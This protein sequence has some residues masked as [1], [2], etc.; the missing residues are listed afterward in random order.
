MPSE[1]SVRF[2]HHK[3]NSIEVFIERKDQGTVNSQIVKKPPLYCSTKQRPSLAWAREISLR[4]AR[5]AIKCLTGQSPK[6][7]QQFTSP[8]DGADIA[9]PQVRINWGGW[10]EPA[11]IGGL[12]DRQVEWA[13]KLAASTGAARVSRRHFSSRG[14]EL[15]SIFDAA[16]VASLHVVG[17]GRVFEARLKGI[18]Q[19][20]SQRSARTQKAGSFTFRSRTWYRV[21]N[22]LDTHFPRIT[23]ALTLVFGPRSKRIHDEPPPLLVL[24]S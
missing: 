5:G 1:E 4:R 8:Q 6:S 22:P 17:I 10:S 23:A 19:S 18:W 14:G 7:Y 11:G 21:S 3:E 13:E 12:V 24:A 20:A 15:S 16:A 2:D 9:A